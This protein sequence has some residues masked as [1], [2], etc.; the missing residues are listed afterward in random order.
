[1]PEGPQLGDE[2]VVEAAASGAIARWRTAEPATAQ[3]FSLRAACADRAWEPTVTASGAS[4]FVAVDASAGL[5]ACDGPVLYTLWHRDAASASWIVLA[6]QPYSTRAWQLETAVFAAYPNPFSQT[7]SIPF[8]L[9]RSGFVQAELYDVACRQ[10][11]TLLRERLETGRGLM[12]RDGRDTRGR[13]LSA[14]IYILHFSSGRQ[15]RT[16]RIVLAR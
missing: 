10:V 8:S 5:R 11:A 2:F 12:T 14:G 1:V 7:V 15:S 13:P 4:T 9:A 6:E 3:Q 16:Q